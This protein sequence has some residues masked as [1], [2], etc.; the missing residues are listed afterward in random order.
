MSSKF[1]E[2]LET[3]KQDVI[4][5]I[6]GIQ[7]LNILR[8]KLYKDLKLNDLKRDLKT[9]PDEIADKQHRA[10]DQKNQIADFEAQMKSIET[11]ISFKVNMEKNDKDKPMFSNAELRKAELSRRLDE[12]QTYL[13]LK[14]EKVK[15]ENSLF[16]MDIGI[17][18]LR[19]QFRT[20][21]ALK[22]LAVT[23]LSIYIK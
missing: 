13:N 20:A 9:L 15:S 14:A 17:E 5:L 10:R 8:E 12:D 4:A 3:A 19:N 18:K 6:D 1:L 16:N 2:E 21:M 22:D 23:E 11:E 7:S